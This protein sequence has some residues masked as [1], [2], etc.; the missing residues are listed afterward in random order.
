MKNPAKGSLG[1]GVAQVDFNTALL[2]ENVS[3]FFK[4]CT[5]ESLQHP[6]LY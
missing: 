4:P 6:G 2:V 5:S 1:L 3:S